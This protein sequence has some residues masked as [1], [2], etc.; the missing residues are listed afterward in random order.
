M[1]DEKVVPLTRD[2][3]V[4]RRISDLPDDAP[5]PKQFSREMIVD[6]DF[7]TVPVPDG[8]MLD[9]ASEFEAALIEVVEMFRV[10]NGG[11]ARP[12]MD[13]FQGF[14]DIANDT[15]QRPIVVAE[16]LM[17]KH[18]LSVRRHLSNWER[19]KQTDDGFSDRVV[20]SIIALC[21]YR[22]GEDRG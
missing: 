6:D 11:Y 14:T 21:L 4:P 18:R 22:R 5:M 17:S 3:P 19:D 12:G 2:E 13:L 7:M 10:K 9:P 1:D 15:E 16:V 8:F 20:Y